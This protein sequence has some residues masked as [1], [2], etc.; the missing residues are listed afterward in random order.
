MPV[1]C[2]FEP[3]FPAKPL[4]MHR[5]DAPQTEMNQIEKGHDENAEDDKQHDFKRVHDTP[6]SKQLVSIGWSN[7]KGR[8]CPIGTS[9]ASLG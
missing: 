5:I 8:L 6:D 4:K 2:H 9:G 3:A 7:V 1:S